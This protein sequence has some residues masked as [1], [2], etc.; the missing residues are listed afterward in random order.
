MW[1]ESGVW[2]LIGFIDDLASYAT[3]TLAADP[4]FGGTAARRLRDIL[5]S[6]C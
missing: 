2:I 5:V 4:C 6:A 1:T 3:K